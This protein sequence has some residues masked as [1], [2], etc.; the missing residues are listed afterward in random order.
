[1]AER[2]IGYVRP[3]KN[4]RTGGTRKHSTGAHH[5][6]SSGTAQS[7]ADTILQGIAIAF[8]APYGGHRLEQDT[9]DRIGGLGQPR[10]VFET[11]DVGPARPL[12][13]FRSAVLGSRSFYAAAPDG[14]RFLVTTFPEQATAAPMTVTLNLA[15]AP[16]K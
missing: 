5:G 6:S 10:R 16:N 1:M 11:F 7:V 9:L 14:E 2:I 13:V 8:T 12:F 3:V 4:S 15:A